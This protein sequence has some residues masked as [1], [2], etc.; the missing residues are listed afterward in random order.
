[1]TS[2]KSFFDQCP[3]IRRV[4][5]PLGV[6]LSHWPGSRAV[7]ALD[8]PR[9]A[10][11]GGFLSFAATHR[12]HRVA[13]KSSRLPVRPR[14]GGALEIGYSFGP[15]PITP[16]MRWLSLTVRSSG[17]VQAS[18][19]R[20]LMSKCSWWISSARQVGITVRPRPRA[21]PASKYTPFFC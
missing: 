3:F 1:M 7:D 5:G 8:G 4:E 10:S 20:C 12:G 14:Q 11:L 13:P 19:F 2:S 6:G 16:L 15:V 9:T 21:K 18:V 17:L